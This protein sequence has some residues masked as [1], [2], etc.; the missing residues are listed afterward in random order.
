[1]GRGIGFGDFPKEI[2]LADVERTFYNV[3]PEQQRFLQDLPVDVVLFSAKVM[4]IVKNELPYELSSN[5]VFLMA[6]HIS[7]AM[8]RI[9][10]GIRIKMPLAYDVQQMY[11]IEYK[12]GQFIVGRVRKE[13]QVL[14]PKEETVGIAMNLVN[15]IAKPSEAASIQPSDRFEDFLEDVTEIVESN[16]RIALDRDSFNFARYATHLQYLFQRIITNQAIKSDNLSLYTN[17]RDEFPNIDQCAG[18]I[19]Q[20]VSKRW[21]VTLTE[22]E[23][24]YLI[25][26]INRICEKEG[27]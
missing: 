16:L 22:E 11:P 17:M 3:E 13:F 2:P 7:F 6:D 10:K 25:L 14:L 20:Y 26:H 21:K 8:E 18:H 1:M 24:L 12:L 9:R 27:L 23:K 4:D 5:A 15:A 19:A